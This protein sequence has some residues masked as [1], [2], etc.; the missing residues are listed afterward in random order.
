MKWCKSEEERRFS[1]AEWHDWFAWHPV[2]IGPCT[3][4]GQHVWRKG[5]PICG[6]D[7]CEWEWEYKENEQ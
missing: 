5:K 1:Y 6:W 2:R 3:I 4:W 7:G